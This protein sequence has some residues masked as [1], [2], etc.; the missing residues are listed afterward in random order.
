[1]N[2][3]LRRGAFYIHPVLTIKRGWTDGDISSTGWAT[4]IFEKPQA[5]DIANELG[6]EFEEETQ[7]F[8]FYPEGSEA[9]S[10]QKFQIEVQLPG[11]NK[12][13]VDVWAI[14]EDSWEWE[15]LVALDLS[16]P[17]NSDYG[18]DDDGGLE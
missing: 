16:R 17:H 10:F 9:Q 14:G 4:P 12:R 11:E 2:T 8:A 18:G 3:E 1:M 7:C 5:I 13:T 15:E 6:G